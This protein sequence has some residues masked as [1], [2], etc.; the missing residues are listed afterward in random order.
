M[1]SCEIE[2]MFER[3]RE[4]PQD[5]QERAI[6]ILIALENGEADTDRLLK[7]DAALARGS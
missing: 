1:K 5:Q 6:K 7:E 3:V 4:W 2:E